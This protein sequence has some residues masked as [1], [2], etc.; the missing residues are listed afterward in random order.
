MDAK[1][2]ARIEKAREEIKEARIAR[3][4]AEADLKAAIA[5]RNALQNM[6][7]HPNKFETSCMGEMGWSCPDCDWS[8]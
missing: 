2:R 3:D 6:C 4:Y 7:D 1:L 8:N 5:R